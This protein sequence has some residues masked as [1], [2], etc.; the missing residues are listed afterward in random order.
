MDED[1]IQRLS[2]GIGISVTEFI[3]KYLAKSENSEG[4][5]F[6]TST[7]PLLVDSLCSHYDHRPKECRSYPHLHKKDF[8][9]RLMNVIDNC[10]VCP[11]VY[12]VYELLKS[13]I[14]TT[15]KEAYL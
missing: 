2:K 14:I 8:T 4:Y 10:S 11:I 6:N 1:D 15:K 9:S 13:R 7:C 3:E 5:R 12:N